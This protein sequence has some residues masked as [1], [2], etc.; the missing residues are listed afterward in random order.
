VR[1]MFYFGLESAAFRGIRIA[2]PQSLAVQSTAFLALSRASNDSLMSNIRED[3]EQDG[4]LQAR[5]LR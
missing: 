4:P 2:F 3:G 1:L 5:S